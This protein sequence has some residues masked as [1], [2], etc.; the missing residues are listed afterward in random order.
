MKIVIAGAGGQGKIVA[1]A[2]LAARRAGSTDEPI[3]YVDDAA[4]LSTSHLGLPLL[5]R[6]DDLAAIEHDAVVVA[7][8]DNAAR[9]AITEALVARGERIV[10][11]IHPFS[12]V[13]PDVQIGEGSMLSAGVVVAPGAMLGRGVLLNTK[14]SVDH[15]SVIGDFAHISVGA[16]VGAGCRIGRET[17]IGLSGSVLS[18]CSVGERAM[19]GAG[20]V[21]VRDIPGEVTALGV[22]ARIT[23]DR[24][25]ERSDH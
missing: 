23:S 22:P 2:L 14:A 18:H 16:T 15:D 1:D 12:S 13:A 21:V 8:G 19:I 7:I 24:R 6:I 4:P 25:S 5:G 20:A 3:G 10:S 11:A 17:F 9:S